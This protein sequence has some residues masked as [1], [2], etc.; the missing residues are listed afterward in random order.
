MDFLIQPMGPEMLGGIIDFG[1]TTNKV[2]GC[3]CNMVQ[4][5]GCPQQIME[6]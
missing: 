1:C 6:A 4:G 3:G 5:C 2:A